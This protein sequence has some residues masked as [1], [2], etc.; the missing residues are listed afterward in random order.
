MNMKTFFLMLC[1]S[2]LLTSCGKETPKEVALTTVTFESADECHLCGM[3]IEVFSGPK[4][5][6]TNKSDTHIRKFCSTRD[7]FSYYL[8][9]ENKRNV[10][11]LLVH[12]MGQ[13]P[14]ESPDDKLMIN[15]KEA[16]FV[17]GSEK[18]GAMGS[19]L[20]SFKDKAI[21]L[22]FAKE[23]GGSVVQFK[24]INIATISDF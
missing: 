11:Q 9:P 2:L 22:A 14:W 4:G 23:F 13:V 15:A 5:A 17:V 3:I 21:A 1:V 7:L 19:T 20:A 10:K 8:D 6:A 12:D 24:N 18:K 16:W